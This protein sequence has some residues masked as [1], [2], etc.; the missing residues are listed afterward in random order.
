MWNKVSACLVKTGLF[1]LMCSV[2]FILSIQVRYLPENTYLDT[3]AEHHRVV[4]YVIFGILTLWVFM[5]VCGAVQKISKAYDK[6]VV[7][8]FLGLIFAVQ[9]VYIFAFKPVLYADPFSLVYTAKAGLRGSLG[10]Y[11][12]YPMQLAMTMLISIWHQAVGIIGITDLL[13]ADAV[14]ASLFMDISIYFAYK[15]VGNLVNDTGKARVLLVF[16]ALNPSVYLWGT[17]LYTHVAS[18]M[19]MTA[20]IYFILRLKDAA[21]KKEVICCTAL[22]TVLS[23]CGACIRSNGMFALLALAVCCLLDVRFLWN[24]KI[25][26]LYYIVPFILALSLAVGGMQMAKSYYMRSSGVY[27]FD[28]SDTKMPMVYWFLIGFSAGTGFPCFSYIADFP[29]QE[30]KVQKSIEKIVEFAK[31]RNFK[32]TADWMELQWRQA[33]GI[34]H[35]FGWYQL[36]IYR[37][38]I[39]HLRSRLILDRGAGLWIYNQVL[40]IILF[41]LILICILHELFCYKKGITKIFFVCVIFAGAIVYQVIGETQPSYQMAWI[42]VLLILAAAGYVWFNEWLQRIKERLTAVRTDLLYKILSAVFVYMAV[43]TAGYMCYFSAAFTETEVSETNHVVS[44]TERD[45]EMAGETVVQSFQAKQPFNHVSLGIAAHITDQAKPLQYELALFDEGRSMLAGQVFDIHQLENDQI[46]ME[47]EMICPQD[48]QMYYLLCRPVYADKDNYIAVSTFD[49]S[50]FDLNEN[51][52]LYADGAGCRRDAKFSVYAVTS[53][54]YYSKARYYLSFA[55]VL[56]LEICLYR[57]LIRI[58]FGG[59]VFERHH[60]ERQLQ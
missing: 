17:Y 32:E 42:T 33:F 19:F 10:Y 36:N 21:A 27:E 41:L 28:A 4:L 24:H 20:A 35:T 38:N 13:T 7:G 54:P 34:G 53:S 16:A 22:V 3:I 55:F 25:H 52:T 44:V 40:L 18:L 39:G 1:L 14:L 30:E 49:E 37:N 9:L 6:A 57:N 8:A 11:L 29:G 50:I 56:L 58:F 31:G 15:T 60:R 43:V 45:G 51:G 46:D 12:T 26:L 23:Y 47:F 48:K 5:K 59:C 2:L